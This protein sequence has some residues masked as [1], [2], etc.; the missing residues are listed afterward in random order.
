M[1]P[2]NGVAHFTGRYGPGWHN[3]R[4]F[5]AVDLMRIA[6]EL[7]EE[8]DTNPDNFRADEHEAWR[9]VGL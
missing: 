9:G 5:A 8:L 7:A 4:P 6:L 3:R 2:M 1:R